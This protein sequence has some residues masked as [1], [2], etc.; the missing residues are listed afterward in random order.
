MHETPFHSFAFQ[1][2]G[3]CECF[4]A[5]LLTPAGKTLGDVAG[6]TLGDVALVL[7]QS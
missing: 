3:G 6:E 5:T 4:T 1:A 7:G 2:D